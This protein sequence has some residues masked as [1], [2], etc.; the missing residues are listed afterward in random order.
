MSAIIRT[1]IAFAAVG[2]GL[3]HVALVIGS[4]LALGIPLAVLGFVEFGWGILAFTRDQLPFARAAMV[5][6]IAPLVAWGLLITAASLFQAPALGAILDVVP[7]GIAAIFQ[8]SVAGMLAR[9]SRRLREGKRAAA[10]TPGAGRY[11]VAL[12]VGALAVSALTTPAL[13]ATEAGIYAQPHG[14]HDGSFTPQRDAPAG[15]SD[16]QLF[17]IPSH[18]GH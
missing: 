7:W 6:A 14:E 12:M 16:D 3:I 10:S 9:Q 17:D 4:P 13:A 5:V 8:L 1:W 18:E 11:L 15:E 2:T